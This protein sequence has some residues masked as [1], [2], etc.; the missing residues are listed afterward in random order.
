MRLM[1]QRTFSA[2]ALSL[3]YW[4]MALLFMGAA[5]SGDC[6]DAQAT[7]EASFRQTQIVTLSALVGV[8]LALLYLIVRKR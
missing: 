2:L 6:F 8:Y 4:F 1:S 5:T 3:C 7:C